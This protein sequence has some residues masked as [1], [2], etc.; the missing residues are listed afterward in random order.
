MHKRLTAFIFTLPAALMSACTPTVRVEPPT[1]PITINLNV[2]IEHEI[3][4][5]VEE[6]LNEIFSE[7]SGLF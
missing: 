2:R 7:D 4:V 1:E 3:R 5:R 6:D